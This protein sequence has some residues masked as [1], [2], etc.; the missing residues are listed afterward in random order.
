MPFVAHP[1]NVVG[2]IQTHVPVGVAGE[3]LEE[4]LACD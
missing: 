1:L 4:R 2:S 3:T